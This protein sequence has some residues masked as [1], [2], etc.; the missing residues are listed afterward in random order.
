MK[1]LKIL[2]LDDK[3]PDTINTTISTIYN[4]VYMFYFLENGLKFLASLLKRV[5]RTCVYNFQWRAELSPVYIRI[6]EARK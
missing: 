5:R 6:K 3:L 4:Y 1:A 2:A